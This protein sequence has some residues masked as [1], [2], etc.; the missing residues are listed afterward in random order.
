M[1]V[2]DAKMSKASLE[3]LDITKLVNGIFGRVLV[4]E[5]VYTRY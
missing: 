2:A 3:I 5:Y 1:K 4:K